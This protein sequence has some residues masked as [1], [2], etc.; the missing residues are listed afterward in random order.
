M[1]PSKEICPECDKN[2]YAKQ[3]YLRCSGE[4]KGRF[5]LKCLNINEDDL[6]SFIKKGKNIYKCKDCE[7]K[8]NPDILVPDSS[9]KCDVGL[10]SDPNIT[11]DCGGDVPKIDQLY[12][13]LKQT[14][15]K[16]NSLVEEVAFLRK[17]NTI[18]LNMINKQFDVKVD[19]GNACMSVDK[20]TNEMESNVERSSYAQV[21]HH[22]MVSHTPESS[23][24]SPNVVVNNKNKVPRKPLFIGTNPRV[25]IGVA[26]R[27]KNVTKAYFVT[28]FAQK[29]QASDVIKLFDD[30]ESKNIVCT[31]LKTKYE[32][33]ASF[34]INVLREFEEEL[35]NPLAWPEGIL[36]A[37]FYGPLR[38][39]QCYSDNA[40]TEDGSELNNNGS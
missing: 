31:R 3:T 24:T 5:H 36:V 9:E 4:C 8:K 16:V 39:E 28:R 35:L 21:V 23:V 38:K 37:P 33:Y 40:P 12:D 13:L 14:L 19:N 17:E 29:T 27:Q 30:A 1:A 11:Q 10:P 25:K 34:H 32:G 2:F 18:L 20:Q 6:S 15:F 7:K 26:P 22:H